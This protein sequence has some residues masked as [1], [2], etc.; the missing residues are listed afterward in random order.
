MKLNAL[1]ESTQNRLMDFYRL[2]HRRDRAMAIR[3]TELARSEGDGFATLVTGGFHSPGIRRWLR[4]TPAHYVEISPRFT[5]PHTLRDASRFTLNSERIPIPS[6]VAAITLLH[7]PER[8]LSLKKHVAGTLRTP[9]IIDSEGTRHLAGFANTRKGPIPF[10]LGGTE[11][12]PQLTEGREALSALRASLL[13][14]GLS[15]RDQ[16]LMEA[17]NIL[18]SPHPR[19]TAFQAFLARTSVKAGQ[20]AHTILTQIQA[21]FPEESSLHPSLLKGPMAEV[22]FGGLKTMFYFLPPHKNEAG[23]RTPEGEPTPE[24]LLK[25]ALALA[26]NNS[27]PEAEQ[28]LRRLHAV[29]SNDRWSGEFFRQLSPQERTN[30][31]GKT[32]T[33]RLGGRPQRPFHPSL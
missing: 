27:F 6:L 13:A 30:A 23:D 11:E 29:D 10:L 22:F 24:K 31:E 28:T 26:R 14:Q 15:D 25:N 16:S 19:R 4:W 20:T 18:L 32:L 33:P 9:Q 3:T 5:E 21:S 7:H 17:L 12:E 8:A 2:A 1:A